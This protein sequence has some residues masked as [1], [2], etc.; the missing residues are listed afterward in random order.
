MNG[1]LPPNSSTPLEFGSNAIAAPLRADGDVA[2]A[3]CSH[4]AKAGQQVA[5][6]AAAVRAARVRCEGCIMV[7][8]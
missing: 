4:W 1:A 5:R 8:R 3:F 2:G 6:I 7:V